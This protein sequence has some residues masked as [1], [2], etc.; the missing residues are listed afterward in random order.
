[1]GDNKVHCK[2]CKEPQDHHERFFIKATGN[3]LIILL[4]WFVKSSYKQGQSLKKL[5]GDTD[6]PIRLKIN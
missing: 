5:N 4:K 6:V 2:N 1:M 3:V